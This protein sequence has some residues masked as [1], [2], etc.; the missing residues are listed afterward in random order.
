LVLI[1]DDHPIV[2]SA[3]E[4][5]LTNAL[6]CRVMYAHSAAEALK[7]VELL[8]DIDLVLLDLKLPDVEGFDGLSQLRKQAPKLPI[9]VISGLEDGRIVQF[10]RGYGAMGFI[11]KKASAAEVINAVRKVLAGDTAFPE[12]P[13][14]GSAHDSNRVPKLICRLTPQ[15]LTVLSMLGEGK[16]NKQIAYELSISESTVKAHVSAILGK[17]EVSSRTQAVLIAQ[18]GMFNNAPNFA[19]AE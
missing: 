7:T 11:S 15:Q 2:C 14:D 6:S 1:V 13:D 10:V 3:L 19:A 8:P 4:A 18:G 5:T 12:M 16:L 9:L 17:L